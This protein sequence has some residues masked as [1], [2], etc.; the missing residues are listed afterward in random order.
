M[1]RYPQLPATDA[2]I[3]KNKDFQS[4]QDIRWCPG[5]GDYSILKQVQSVL[6]TLGIPR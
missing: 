3:L 4:D 1:T 2:S 5:C 6:P